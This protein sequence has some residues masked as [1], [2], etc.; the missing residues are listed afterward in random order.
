MLKITQENFDNLI[1]GFNHRMT[2]VETSIRYIKWIIGYIA[3]I[4]SYSVF[5]G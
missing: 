3:L 4:M 5:V 2:K 1:E